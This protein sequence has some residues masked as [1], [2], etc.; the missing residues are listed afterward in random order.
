MVRPLDPY[1]NAQKALTSIRQ[2]IFFGA[3]DACVPNHEQHIP[4]DEYREN[5]KKIIQH[6]AT[7]AQNPR[8]ILITPPPIN[9]YQL[10]DF[11]SE[12]GNPY[13]SRTASLAKTYAEA[14][15]EVAASLNIPSA[16]IWSAFMAKVG[17]D[18]GKPLVGSRNLP[19][20]EEFCSLFTDGKSKS[21]FIQ[22]LTDCFIAGLHLTA[23]GYR[24]VYDEVVKVIRTNWPDQD[25]EKLPF[26][27][28]PWVDAPK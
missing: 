13:P 21:V 27:F 10:E 8:I 24:I 2:T 17:W 23:A 14:A 22:C 16:D 26:V 12:K 1:A 11:D 28:P 18:E 4:L 25:P 6:P 20:N 15:R 3:N 5:L 7:Q 9:E 19:N